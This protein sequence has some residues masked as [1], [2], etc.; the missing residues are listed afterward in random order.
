M[1]APAIISQA[2]SNGLEELNHRSIKEFMGSEHLPFKRFGMNAAYYYLMVLAHFITEAFR[3]DV[4]EDVIPQRYYPTRL[5]RGLI[6]FAA[7]II[8][9]GGKTIMKVTETVFEGIHIDVLWQR[10]NNPPLPIG[11]W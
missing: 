7:K 8:R 11:A 1:E 9:S 3:K 2:H 4:A 10:C 5:R 6:D